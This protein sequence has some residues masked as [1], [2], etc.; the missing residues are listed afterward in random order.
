M[1]WYTFQIFISGIGSDAD[2]AWADAVEN[3]TRKPKTAP[4]PHTEEPADPVRCNNCDWYGDD[5]DLTQCNDSRGDFK[6]CPNCK[7]DAYLMDC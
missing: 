6:G 2:E 7:T 1:K 5:E 3:F 4:E